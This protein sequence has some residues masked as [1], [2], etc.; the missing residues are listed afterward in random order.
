MNPFQAKKNFMQKSD[1][2]VLQPVNA[3]NSFRSFGVRYFHCLGNEFIL[4]CT[5]FFDIV[6]PFSS[7]FGKKIQWRCHS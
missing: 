5:A 2:K 7:S 4:H 6:G 3:V 1:R